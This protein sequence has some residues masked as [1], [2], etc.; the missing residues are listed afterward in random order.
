MHQQKTIHAFCELGNSLRNF[1]KEYPNVSNSDFNSALINIVEKNQQ[2]NGWF[3][4]ENILFAL[5][6]I[7]TMLTKDQLIPFCTN[8]DTVKV[9]KQVA[10]IMAGNIPAV[11]FHD[12]MCVLLSGNKILLKYSSD[13][14]LLIPFFIKALIRFYP[15]LQDFILIAEGKLHSFDAVIATGTNNTYRYFE[16]YFSSYPHIFRKNRTSVAVVKGNETMEDLRKL[17]KDIFSYFGLG[18]RNVSHLI[19]PEMYDFR[20]FFEA[21]YSYAD[22]M[23]NK[24]Y[25]NNYDYNRAVYLLNKEELLDNNFLL[26]RRSDDLFSPVAVL[27]YHCYHNNSEILHYLESHKNEI[28][29]VVCI[30]SF[31][32]SC[33]L[34]GNA[35]CPS[36]NDFAD[37]I[38]TFTFLTKTI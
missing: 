30:D 9:P 11:G 13:D 6:G 3:T 2:Y 10:V 31:N 35:Q 4:P 37:S 25:A 34:P 7:E 33:V 28:Q 12:L 17:A 18:C 27:N 15:A 1:L 32:N 20:P 26:L 29:C 23:N 24:K 14:H 5:K 21:V 38:D 36:I 8:Y 22:L 16:H 19:V